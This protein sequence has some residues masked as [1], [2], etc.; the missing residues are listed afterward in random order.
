MYGVSRV[1]FLAF[2]VVEPGDDFVWTDGI[3]STGKGWRCEGLGLGV[4]CYGWDEWL[5][6]VDCCVRIKVC[7]CELSCILL[8]LLVCARK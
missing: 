3:D 8:L 4:L 5:L 2:C 1:Y 6:V 7:L